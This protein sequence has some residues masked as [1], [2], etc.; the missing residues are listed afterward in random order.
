MD[1]LADLLTRARARGAVFAHSTLR[2]DWGLE[3]GD[4]QPLS[5]H[6]VLE[7]ELHVETDG[8]A[9]VRLLQGDLLLVRSPSPYRFVHRPGAAAIPVADVA[10]AMDGRRYESPGDG[11]ATVVVCGAYSFD[12]S[13]CDS[14]LAAIPRLL[15]LRGVSSTEPSVRVAL[16]LLA[17]ELQR[18]APGQPAVLDR[19]LDLL[20]VYTLRAWFAREDAEAPAWY[21]A[22]DDPQV[23]AALRALHGA[24]SRA[25]SVADLAAE[26]GLSRA[27]F[28]RRFSDATGQ[29][30]LGYL[31]EWRMVLATQEL[32]RPG[33]TLASVAREI[34]Y[35][36]EFAFANAFKRHHGVP[37]GRWRREH[38]V[39]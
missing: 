22:L 25:W 12:G 20:L 33:A 11:P 21:G 38:A 5:L 4:E 13:I 14:L 2:G 6:A 31:T 24:P 10:D 32:R 34:G 7:G 17:E 27:A 36:S 19:L 16:G 8:E 37:P 26:A 35:G 1:V 3:F 30:P 15:P 18:E 28:A 9:P 39:A 29:A 23:G